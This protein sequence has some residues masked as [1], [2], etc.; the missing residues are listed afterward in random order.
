MAIVGMIALTALAPYAVAAVGIP[1]LGMAAGSLTALGSLASAAIVGAGA[2]LI[3]HFLQ[4]KAGGKSQADPLYN[5]SLQGNQARPMQPIPVLN[6]RVRFAPEYAAPT[7]SEY[8][9]DQMIDYAL[10]GL[11]CGEMDVEEIQIGDTSIWTAAGGYNADYPGIEIQIVP[12]GQQVTL[13]PVNVVSAGELQGAELTTTYTPGIIVNAA[14]TLAREL[15]FDFMWGNG[16]YRTGDKGQTLAASTQI[17]IRIRAVDDAGAP[18]G[19]WQEV[20]SK[21][22][23]QAKQ[24][25]IRVTERFPVP[26]ARYEVSVKR[27]NPPLT[28]TSRGQDAVAWTAARASIDG[29]NSFPRL[30]TL[31]VKG[32]GNKQNSG[33]SGG[34]LRVIG[35]RR[36]PVW[37]LQAQQFI[38]KPTRSIAW[39]A[40]DWWRN[41]DYS[42]GLSVSNVDLAAFIAYDQLWSSLGHTFDFRFTEVQTLDEVLETILKAGRAFPAPVGDKLTITRDQPRGLAR[43]LF[44]DND[45]VAGSL[46]ID[47]ALA[48]E[49]WADGIVGEYVDQSTWRLAEVS[50]A[51]DGVV[52][53]N[54]ARV[55]LQGV[56]G[57]TQAT[58]MV[59]MMAA[60]SQYRRVTVSWTAR[61]EGRLL[62]RGDLV[63]ISTE[64]PET[65]GASH[66]IISV[67]NSGFNLTLD[68]VPDWNQ[69]GTNWIEIRMRDGRPFGPVRVTRGRVD[70]EA[71]VNA[72]D[73]ASAA[74]A[75]SGA[76]GYPVSLADAVAR[77]STQ[78][79][80]WVAFSPGQQRS[81]P[82]LITEGTPDQDGEHIALK[83]VLDAPEVYTTTESG[84]PPLLQI[85]DLFSSALPT[86]LGL[87]AMIT[88]QQAHLVLS[89]G[90][91]PARNA[92]YYECTLSYD[93]GATWAAI[94]RTD[95]STFEAVVGASP[96]MR[97]RVRGVTPN[98][99]PGGWSVVE[100]TAPDLEIDGDLFADLSI[101]IEKMSEQL[102][103]DIN[104]INDLGR[105]LL[106]LDTDTGNVAI[107][108]AH[109]T[110]RGGLRQLAAATERLAAAAATQ[111]TNDYEQR[112]LIKVGNSA[113]FAAIER[114]EIARTSAD[115][116]LASVQTALAARL[117][118]D[119]GSIVGNATAIQGLSSRVTSAEGTITAQAL[120]ITALSSRIDSTDL[121]LSGQATAIQGL[122]TRVTLNEQGISSVSQQVTALQSTIADAQGNITA[123]AQAI[124]TLTAQTAN[125]NGTLSAQATQLNVLSTTLG[126]HTATLTEYGASIDGVRAQYGVTLDLDGQTGGFVLSGARRLDGSAAFTFGIR[127]DLFVDGTIT[128][129]ALAAQDLIVA[130][131]Q[132]GH[133]VVGTGNLANRSVTQTA[134]ST[135]V[136]AS[137]D[138]VIQT[139]VDN[140][141]VVIDAFF[142]GSGGTRFRYGFANPGNLNVYR[143]GVLIGQIPTQVSYFWSQS[144]TDNYVY[145][146]A[147]PLPLQ[148]IPG[149]AGIY[150]Y[151]VQNDNTGGIGGVSIRV[152]ELT[153]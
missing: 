37:D 29:P 94:M 110:I 89:A 92:V 47:Y 15:I 75:A 38:T 13:Y 79:A 126:G 107:D 88:Q 148:D 4:P 113:N 103:R 68:P 60:E 140:A 95:S 87:Y 129:R 111:T 123:N 139:R 24:T 97:F 66:E 10:F 120:S 27:V 80:P 23:T 85:P 18:T 28:D 83:G 106:A 78:E 63:R 101:R 105:G 150:T 54:P 19:P 40:L 84:V 117:T 99:V 141:Q 127:G 136:A 36:L 153:R 144:I 67:A 11:T 115:E 142:G 143:N 134:F 57:R 31:A 35:T 3:S 71:I 119:E 121:S 6:G 5:F 62:K 12:P 112:R 46:E 48:D 65:W 82:V 135:T 108:L 50:S 102:Q 59:R 69:A 70:A 45:I 56:V 64:E 17:E 91:Q 90:W 58:G 52:L 130:S 77:S 73:A 49:A 118:L 124:N 16:A 34:Q 147:T 22:Y 125:I 133:L 30:T 128:G 116:S 81:Y 53:T 25:Q 9:G 132:I 42:A 131:A 86:I 122:T 96:N 137:T 98:G 145:F 55:Q 61:M 33:V 149:P 72:N 151:T 114:E 109:D 1:A 7:Y 21:I 76:Y 14:G 26:G 43:M 20:W 74:S 152:T 104:S 146:L 93:G 100:V 32:T 8:S 2:F 51:P 44:T 41:S 138:A 39:A